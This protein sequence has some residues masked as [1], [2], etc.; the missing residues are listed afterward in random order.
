MKILRKK[1]KL[2]KPTSEYVDIF[3]TD[4]KFNV[5]YADPPWQYSS[6][7]LQKYD[8]ERFR[9][10]EEEYDTMTIEDIKKLPINK[11]SD[12]DCALFMWVTDSHLKEGIEVIEAW[13]F[14]YV[15]VVFI[16]EKL[17]S[18]GNSVSNV[19][20]WTMKNCEICLLAT[21]G[22]L[23]KYKKCNNLQQIVKAERTKHSRKPNE[24]RQRIDKLFGDIPRLELFAREYPLGWNVWGNEVR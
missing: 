19:A 15:T 5:I 17:S 8:G 9:P 13:G 18:K 11:L 14:K 16:W 4:K 3:K 6:K 24:V 20:P 1:I 23:T 22:H 12:K 2:V 21:K 10:L 7:Q